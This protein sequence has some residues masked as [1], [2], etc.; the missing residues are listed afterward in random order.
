MDDFSQLN[1]SKLAMDEMKD[2]QNRIK[3]CYAFAKSPL[4][5]YQDLCIFNPDAKQ[6]RPDYIMPTD[7]ILYEYQNDDGEEIIPLEDLQQM[8]QNAG[9]PIICVGSH[10]PEQDRT[11][12]VIALPQSMATP[13]LEPSDLLLVHFLG[14]M[15]E[16]E[17]D[18]IC[19][20]LI[21]SYET[22]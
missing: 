4:F 22:M 10:D 11:V 1:L 2:E 9:T 13:P 20:S 7:L 12:Q 17:K 19:Q 5:Y 8:A 6:Y 3:M 21:G 18:E 15:S 16:E 14:P